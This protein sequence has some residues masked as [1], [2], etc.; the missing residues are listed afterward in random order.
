MMYTN[1]LYMLYQGDNKLIHAF[2]K[3]YIASLLCMQIFFCV[4]K[5]E[6]MI[7]HC[8]HKPN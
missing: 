1:K 5:N 3:D 2:I 7:V 8:Q 4:K 6:E